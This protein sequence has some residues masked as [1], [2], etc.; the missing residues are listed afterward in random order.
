MIWQSTILPTEAEYECAGAGIGRP[1]FGQ[2]SGGIWMDEVQCSGL[3]P[4]LQDCALDWGSNNC[5]IF[6]DSGLCCPLPNSSSQTLRLIG[7]DSGCGRVEIL[8][9]GTWGSICDD[10]W[11]DTHASIVCRNLFGT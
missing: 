4:R 3:E 11:S 7:G 5:T 2:G 6:Q 9:D 10:V 8:R 1:H